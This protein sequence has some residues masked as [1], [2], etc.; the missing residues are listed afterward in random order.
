M[1]APLFVKFA[2]KVRSRNGVV[3]DNLHISG[4]DEAEALRRLRQMY[5]NSEVL[6]SNLVAQEKSATNYEAVLDMIAESR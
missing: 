6:S 4:R 5:P 3:V 2:F 1:N